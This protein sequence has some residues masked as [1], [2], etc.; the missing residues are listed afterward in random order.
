MLISYRQDPG[1][2][3]IKLKKTVSNRKMTFLYQAG[4]FNDTTN[5]LQPH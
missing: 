5:W 2:N 4:Q 1:V 3:P